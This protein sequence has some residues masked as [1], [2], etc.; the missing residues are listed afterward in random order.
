MENMDPRV[1]LICRMIAASSLE[2]IGHFTTI[3][4]AGSA[5]NL[6]FYFNVRHY[7]HY[8]KTF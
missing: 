1:A 4:F 6:I 7:K 5:D 3:T 8:L 2:K